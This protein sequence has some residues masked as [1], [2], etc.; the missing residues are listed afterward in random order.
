[1][2]RTEVREIPIAPWSVADLAIM[3]VF[4]P[5]AQTLFKCSEAD[6]AE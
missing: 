3:P 1:M 6:S 4:Y 2:R 5:T